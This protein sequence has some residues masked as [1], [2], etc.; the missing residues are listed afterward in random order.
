M[1]EC[2]AGKE[3]SGYRKVSLHPTVW[4]LHTEDRQTD[5]HVQLFRLVPLYTHNFSKLIS[6]ITKARYYGIKLFDVNWNVCLDADKYSR[7]RLII[8]N[9]RLSM[10]LSPSTLL[11]PFVSSVSLSPTSHFLLIHR[12]CIMAHRLKAWYCSNVLTRF[13][14]CRIPSSTYKHPLVL[15]IF[16]ISCYSSLPL[17]TSYLFCKKGEEGMEEDMTVWGDTR[18]PRDSNWE[19][20]CTALVWGNIL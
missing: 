17:S 10:S 9:Y 19:H 18:I 14:T 2:A 1:P 15:R 8:G 11:L 3:E 16:L 6:W 12:R 5:R 20:S 7:F 4:G 13:Q